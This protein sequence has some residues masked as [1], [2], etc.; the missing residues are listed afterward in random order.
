MIKT[1]LLSLA[2]IVSFAFLLLVS[3]LVSAALAAVGDYWATLLPGGGVVLQAVNF[4]A[5]L[6]VAT[7][8]FAMIFKVL[9]EVRIAWRDVW[10]GAAATALLFTLGKLAIGM[11]LGK[12]GLASAYGAAGSLVVILVW[13]YYS[14]QILFFGAEF[15]QA[16]ANTYGSRLVYREAPA[17]L[18]ET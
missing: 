18:S 14:S 12:S 11:Y 10:L 7:L 2:M 3:L 16:Y 8:L 9:P 1:R 15:T 13:V 6:G 5:S 17:R 4:V